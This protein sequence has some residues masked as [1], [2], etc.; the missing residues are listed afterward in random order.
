MATW[1]CTTPW[2]AWSR[3]SPAL[4]A[5][6]GQGN[7]LGRRRPPQPTT[8]KRASPA[9]C[10]H[11]GGYRQE[12][13]RVRSQLRRRH[14]EP[15]VRPCRLPNLLVNGSS[16]HCGRHDDEHPAAQSERSRRRSC[17]SSIIPPPRSRTSG[18]SS[19]SAISTGAII[20]GREGIKDATRRASRIVFRARAIAEE[21][22]STGKQQIVVTDSPIR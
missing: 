19:K 16:G 15:T 7:W 10:G 6:G 17:I 20:Y 9:C 11:A 12:H 4:P 3:T 5:G 14:T 13:R 1:R 8:P 22:E 18:S 21:K 2:Y